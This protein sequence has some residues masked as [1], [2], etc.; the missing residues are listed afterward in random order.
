MIY[1]FTLPYDERNELDKNIVD[2]L[3]SSPP[4]LVKLVN[5]LRAGQ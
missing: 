2:S 5:L 1:L 3:L 4:K